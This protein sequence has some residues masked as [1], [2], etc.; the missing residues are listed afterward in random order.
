MPSVLHLDIFKDLF[1]ERTLWEPVNEG[2]YRLFRHPLYGVGQACYYGAALIVGS[3]P[4]VLANQILL[5]LFCLTVEKN[6][7]LRAAE[8]QGPIHTKRAM[9][10][11]SAH[12]SSTPWGSER[13]SPWE[14]S[15][16]PGDFQIRFAMI[17]L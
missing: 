10:S 16:P 9:S 4:G 6:H 11:P 13:L 15:P 1:L 17:R 8:A 3:A 7:L 12:R 2:P 5:Y 14:D